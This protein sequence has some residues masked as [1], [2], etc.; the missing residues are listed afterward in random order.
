MQPLP[1]GGPSALGPAFAVV[2]NSTVCELDEAAGWSIV[3][4]PVDLVKHGIWI[5]VG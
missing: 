2:I 3:A 5:S 4:V 1:P